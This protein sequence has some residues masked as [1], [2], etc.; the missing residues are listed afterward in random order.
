MISIDMITALFCWALDWDVSDLTIIFTLST[1]LKPYVTFAEV[2]LLK[3]IARMNG[4]DRS[5]YIAR[6]NG[7][8]RSQLGW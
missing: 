4:A 8:H 1:S 5:L 7:A 2:E 6:M 3:I